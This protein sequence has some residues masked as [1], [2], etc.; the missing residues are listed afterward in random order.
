MARDHSH[1]ICTSMLATTIL[2]YAVATIVVR[3]S[4]CILQAIQPIDSAVLE[5][6]EGTFESQSRI[7]LLNI[8]LVL[9]SLLSE[10][11]PLT[12]EA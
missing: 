3:Y 9:S 6:V 5:T 12:H 4:Y 1:P 10:F 7:R 11:Y 8:I 2:T